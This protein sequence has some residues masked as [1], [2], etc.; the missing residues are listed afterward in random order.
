M[1]GCR[2][3]PFTTKNHEL[4]LRY[5]GYIL[6]L[7]LLLS[8]RIHADT[9]NWNRFRGPNGQGV[10]EAVNLPTTFDPATN[11]RWKTALPEGNSSPVIWGNRI[12]LT[13]SDPDDGKSLVTLCIDREDGSI[14]WRKT[15]Q[16]ESKAWHHPMN[17]PAA[18]TPVAD[19]ERVISY[20]GTYG[21]VC[22]DHA[23]KELWR[24]PIEA[25]KNSY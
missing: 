17:N 7:S 15:V 5:L 2:T 20:F 3:M 21:L 1:F 19:A 6:S 14:L 16:A 11:T 18:S 25:P 12:F 22:Y 4:G 23:G 13:A 9:A 10:A 8:V 24:R